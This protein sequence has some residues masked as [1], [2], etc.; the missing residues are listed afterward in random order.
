MGLTVELLEEAQE[1]AFVRRSGLEEKGEWAKFDNFANIDHACSAK[2]ENLLRQGI[3]RFP[4]ILEFAGKDE[5]AMR[6]FEEMKIFG[7]NTLIK[8]HEIKICKCTPDI[9]TCNTLLADELGS[10]RSILGDEESRVY[11]REGYFQHSNQCIQSVWFF[12]QAMGVYQR[13]T[14][15]RLALATVSEN[16]CRNAKWP[17]HCK[18]NELTYN[19][20]EIE[21]MHILGEEIYFGITQPHIVLLKTLVLVF[22][23][24]SD[25]LMETEHVFWS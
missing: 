9:I 22:F 25:L 13:I 24:K 15:S 1:I 3:N 5:P 12:D 16:T 14:G 20:K 10:F 17:I 8:M 2:R 6:V 19:G 21:R 7:C 23:S 18:S 4:I 11:T